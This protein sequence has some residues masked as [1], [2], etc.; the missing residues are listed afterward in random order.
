MF[1]YSYWTL[2]R[3]VD[4]LTV[5]LEAAKKCDNENKECEVVQL[6]EQ[7]VLLDAQT[8]LKTLVDAI[9]TASQ[10]EAEAHETAIGLAK[11]NEELRTELKV[12]IED[13]KRLVELY[14][15]AIVN[16]EVKQDGNYPS[17]PQTE[18]V[19]EQQSSHPS[20][21][22]N[23]I[24]LDDQPEDVTGFPAYDSSSDA[25]E[26]PKIVD[27]KCSHKD[28]LSRSEFSELQLQLEEMHEEND[29]LMSLYE[30]AMQERDEF[31]RKFSEQKNSESTEDIQFRETDAGM[32]EAV[33]T[34]GIQGDN[35]QDSPIVEIG[36]AHV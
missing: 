26:E 5:E 27:G 2:C 25:V 35:A 1:Y 11:E 12:L 9:A 18:D 19:N 23:D 21:G 30:T 6:Q 8:E 22:G 34:E 29:K 10:R 32:D 16:I 24:M 20:G 4:Q 31:K 17:V 36:R 33:D 3:R 15:H 7:S 14:E 13:N 28:D